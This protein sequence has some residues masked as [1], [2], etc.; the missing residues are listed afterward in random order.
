MVQDN[1]VLD[2]RQSILLH[3]GVLILTHFFLEFF[4]IS[5]V[6]MCYKVKNKMNIN[7]QAK[8]PSKLWLEASCI[9]D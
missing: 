2:M 1:W 8:N 3:L 4:F 9:P 6:N 7:K 5:S